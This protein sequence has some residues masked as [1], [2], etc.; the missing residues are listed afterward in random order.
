M[1]TKQQ[2]RRFTT[3]RD[4]LLLEEVNNK[5]PF[6]SENEANVWE[7][8]AKNLDG[9][10]TVKR[11]NG[12]M[13]IKLNKMSTDLQLFEKHSVDVRCVKERTFKLIQKFRIKEHKTHRTGTEQQFERLEELLSLIEAS[14]KNAAEERSQ[15]KKPITQPDVNAQISKAV[16][17][18][19]E[20]GKTA[21]EDTEDIMLR[22]I[23]DDGRNNQLYLNT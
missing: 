16:R 20:E 13:L 19:G 2:Q 11:Y 3:T 1:A 23:E 6:G 4:I 9:A 15:R 12:K 8:I 14:E 7:Q 10:K 18:A 21:E 17:K 5:S 22:E